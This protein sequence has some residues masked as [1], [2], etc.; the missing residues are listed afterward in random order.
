M[1]YYL[2]EWRCAL[3]QFKL[4][5]FLSFFQ[6]FPYFS[7]FTFLNFVLAAGSIA[8]NIASNLND[9]NN[10]NN[11]NNND[12]NDNSNNIGIQNNNNNSNNGNTI[13]LPVGRR[14]RRRRRRMVNKI[15]ESYENIIKCRSDF[16]STSLNI[17]STFNKTMNLM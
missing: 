4:L 15:L 1:K 8:A 2:W 12:N 17:Q 13:M 10:N 16:S 7:A 5:F 14:R 3:Y 11:N 9:N 6:T